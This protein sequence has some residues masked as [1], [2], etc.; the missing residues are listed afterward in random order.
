VPAEFARDPWEVVGEQEV[1][2]LASLGREKRRKMVEE[3]GVA[4]SKDGWRG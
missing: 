2:G 1:I 3:K 4:E